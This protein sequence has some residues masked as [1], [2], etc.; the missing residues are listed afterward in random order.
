MD[1]GEGLLHEQGAA[2]IVGGDAEREEHEGTGYSPAPTLVRVARERGLGVLRS[3]LAV[4]RS[5]EATIARVVRP[6]NTNP[7][8]LAGRVLAGREAR[9]VHDAYAG[10]AEAATGGGE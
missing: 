4:A 10:V 6:S 7:G 2:G 1:A 9:V 5:A 3:R 8:A